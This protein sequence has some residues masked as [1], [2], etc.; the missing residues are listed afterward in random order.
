MDIERAKKIIEEHEIDALIASSPENIFYTSGFPTYQSAR[1]RGIFRACVRSGGEYAFTVV[2]RE[3]EPT[4][5]C[6]SGASGLV[7]KYVKI[8]DVRYYATGMYVE[9]PP[10]AQVKI[11]AQTAFDCLIKLLEEKEKSKATLAIEKGLISASVYEKLRIKL[12]QATLM[13]AGEV[14][15]ELRKIKSEKEIEKM[16]VATSVNE[17]AI[18]AAIDKI[19]EGVKEEVILKEYKRVL[20]ERDCDWQS[21]TTIGGGANSGEPYNFASDYKLKKGDIIRFDMVPAYEG[22]CSDLSRVACVGRPSERAKKIFEAIREAELT[23]IE[24]MK[25]G[26]KISELFHLGMDIVRKAGY[27]NFARGNIGHS[28]GLVV[29]EH[30]EISPTTKDVLAPGM[31]LAVELPYYSIGFAG[32]N[33]EDDVLITNKGHQ[34]LSRE[35]SNEMFIC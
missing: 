25:P 7:D 15:T 6:V 3:G 8:K 13:D 4:F 26:V 31:I 33:A 29:H 17:A 28:L 14:F 34:V 32:F 35:L 18:M 2:P 20:L 5:I 22:Y 10:N 24:S 21:A 23:V 16:K 9:R 27:P 19:H 30:P 12:P 11:F 1:N